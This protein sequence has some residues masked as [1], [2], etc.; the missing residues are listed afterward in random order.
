M[1]RTNFRQ[2][3]DPSFRRQTNKSLSELTALRTNYEKCQ[4]ELENTDTILNREKTR[5]EEIAFALENARNSL[6]VAQ[7]EIDADYL[8]EGAQPRARIENRDRLYLVSW[9]CRVYFLVVF[10][11]LIAC[12]TN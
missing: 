3:V 5:L 12:A 7:E 9:Q 8:P 10:I 4:K 2:N 11:S 6:S 1:D